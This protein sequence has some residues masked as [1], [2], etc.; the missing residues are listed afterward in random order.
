M[1]CPTCA[2]QSVTVWNFDFATVAR[3]ADAASIYQDKAKGPIWI[4]AERWAPNGLHQGD[5]QEWENKM[6]VNIKWIPYVW[7]GIGIWIEIGG[8]VRI[9]GVIEDC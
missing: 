2:L 4:E 1:T 6:V 5:T 3:L 7:M 8:Q 9:E